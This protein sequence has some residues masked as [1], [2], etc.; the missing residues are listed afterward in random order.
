MS[1]YIKCKRCGN[2]YIQD[3]NYLKFI[4]LDCLE[5]RAEWFVFKMFILSILWISLGALVYYLYIK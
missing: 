4:C 3:C 1:E 2:N 5:K